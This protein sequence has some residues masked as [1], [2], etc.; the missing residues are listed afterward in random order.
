MPFSNEDI[1]QMNQN[2]LIIDELQYDRVALEEKYREFSQKCTDEQHHVHDKVLSAVNSNSGGM[3][4]LYGYGGTGK[5]FIWKGLSAALRSKGD[6]VINVASSGIASLS[7]PGG[8]TAHSRFKIP[9]NANEDLTC[10]IKQGSDLAN[11]I[12]RAKLI[13]WDEA[14]MMHKFCFEALDKTLRDIMHFSCP[15]R[16]DVPFGSKTIVF[17]GDFRQILAVVPKESIQLEQFAKWIASIGDG[18]IGGP[19]D[20]EVEIELSDEI[21]IKYS[22]DPIAAIERAIL[23]PTLNVVE[24]INQYMVSLNECEGRKYLSSDRTCTT[25]STSSLLQDIHTPEFLNSLKCSGVPNHELYLKVGTPVMLLRNID[26]ANG[27]CN[28]TRLVITRLHSHVLEAKVIAGQNVGNKVFI[29]RM[30]LT[31]SDSRLPFKFQRKQFPIIVCYAMMINK[32]QGQSLSHVGLFLKKPVFSPGQ[33][34]VAVSRVT[35]HNDLKILIC[36]N[37]DDN[38]K[39]ATTNVVYKEVLQNI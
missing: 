19:N 18:T 21:L 34:Y 17:G 8:R 3:F 39:T 32:S 14:P 16:Y 35:N 36:E 7:L 20:G 29:P 13:I 2:R 10:D 24:S 26:H 27:L 11:L 15:H 1:F 37:D 12:M 31:P 25:D 28:G 4:F 38:K 5:T 22:G 23:A 9:I 30:S 6:I 33:L